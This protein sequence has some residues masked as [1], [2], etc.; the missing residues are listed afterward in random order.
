MPFSDALQTRPIVERVH[1]VRQNAIAAYGLAF[2]L[3][4]L[5]TLIR[6]LVG[7]YVGARIPFI[8]FYPAIII[9]TLV[10][11][12]W[13][14]V[15][16]T[17]FSSLAAWYLFLTPVY[18]WTFEEREL[19]Q[20]FLFIFICGIN[21]TFV[22]LLNALVDRVMAQA[23]NMRVVFES[24]PNGIILVDEQ[25]RIK[26]VNASI[27]KLFGYKGPELL[28]RNVEVLVPDRQVDAHRSEREA[29]LRK[30]EARPMGIG[31]D[32]S[33]QRKDG[34]E[35]PIEIGLNPISHNGNVLA[36]V[37]D[38]SER[39]R[40]QENARE[41][42]RLVI[43]ELQH[44]TK[45]LF[46]VFQAIASR[47]IDEGKT[48][49][50]I[51]YVLNGRLQALGRAYEMLA[52]A[53]WEGISLA[54]ILDR[55]FGGFSERLKVSGCDI[56][57]N[58]SAAHQFAMIVHELATNALKYGS[59]SASRGD[60][61]VEGK[62]ERLNGG[63]V[64][65]FSWKERGG[66]PVPSPTRKGFGSVILLD[67][68][69]QFSQSVTMNYAPAGLTYDLVISLSALEASKNLA[70]QEGSVVGSRTASQ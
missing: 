43:E 24:A 60:V 34:S 8:T 68:A 47:A 36:T 41:S 45:N 35:F 49:A 18:S 19:I 52:E 51:K 70:K 61:L 54:Q 27:E 5:A 69:R 25:G 20:L 37:I 13:P 14:G 67:S 66:P 38:I 22:A 12:L 55:Q 44:R 26:L 53:A 48:A 15:V 33:G 32:L 11:G 31:R 9:A 63:G 64:F 6:W 39:K 30:P 57:V 10:G 65:L 50:E 1:R 58:P 17:I 7:E 62:I 29:F 16:A 56:V 3:V 46:A 40:V 21:V 4:A 23:K 42:Q 59:L 2:A 28:G